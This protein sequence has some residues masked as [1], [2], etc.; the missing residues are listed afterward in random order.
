MKKRLLTI[1]S[2]LVLIGLAWL[3]FLDTSLGIQISPETGNYEASYTF[4]I[5]NGFYQSDHVL[6]VSLLPSLKD[7]YSGRSHTV[8]NEND[9][10]KF[11]TPDA[12]K[13]IAENIRNITRGTP[14]DDEEFANAVLTIVHQ[15][16]Y[17]RSN[18]KYPVETLADNQADCDG[19]SILAASIMK[20]GG[21]DAVLLLYNGMNPTHMNVGVCLERMPVSHSWWMAPSGIDY[22]NK[23]YWIAECTSL[24][25]WTVGTRPE[26]LSQ[27]KPEVIPLE[28]CEKKSPASISSSLNPMQPSSISINLSTFNC[29]A[30]GN[31]RT[32]NVSGSISPAFLNESIAFYVNQPNSPPSAFIALADDFGNYTLLWNVTLP[33]TYIVRTCWSGG[34]N[35]SGS[36][37]ESLTVFVGAQPPPID[38][39]SDYFSG[40]ES[41]SAQS[42]ANSPAYFALLGQS[43]KKFLESSLAG[44]NIMLSGDFMILS[45]GHE[46]TLNETTVTIPARQIAYRLPRSKQVVI[47]E[48]PEKTIT[49]PGAELLNSQFGFILKSDGE[50][51]YTA[52]VK[53]LTAD[54]VSQMTQSLDERGALFMNASEVAAKNTWRKAIAKVSGEEVAIEVYDENGTQLDS[55]TKNTIS[56]Q[57][58]E[59]GILMSYPT[60]Q[61]LA[62]KNLKVESLGQ[63]PTPIVQNQTQGNAIDFLFP[64][65]RI[66]LLLAGIVLAILCLRGR[67]GRKISVAKDQEQL[68]NKG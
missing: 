66:P 40:D 33:G 36:E 27:N 49:F 26:L 60:G 14:Y 9:Y 58:G 43:G 42:W 39:P 64:Y 41:S 18:A 29:S 22:N 21:L 12:V 32:I 4:T 68:S 24:A 61:V 2:L 50:N 48:I 62:F 55:M 65:V 1:L 10:P 63:T 53:L 16:P 13:S 52:S 67:K 57:Y 47:V 37:S 23:T 54:D 31:E 11:V 59:L 38:A 44:T 5:Q 3:P 17:V 6:Y 34:F 51:N 28:K 45:D 19:L 35:F 20:A 8:I 25:D 30:S 7:Y 56:G 46:P 15:I